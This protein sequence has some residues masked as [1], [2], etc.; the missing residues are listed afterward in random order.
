MTTTD[1][2]HLERI[3]RESASFARKAIQKS[4]EIEVYLSLLEARAGKVTR[5]E[6]VAELF[7]TLKLA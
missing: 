6:S 5:H 3:A 1:A 7:R 2:K 4:E